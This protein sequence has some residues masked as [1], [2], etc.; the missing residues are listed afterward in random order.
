MI[1]RAFSNWSLCL[2]TLI[3]DALSNMHLTPGCNFLHFI[4]NPQNIFIAAMIMT[5]YLTRRLGDHVFGE[6]W[7]DSSAAG[8]THLSQGIWGPHWVSFWSTPFN[9]FNCCK[10]HFCEVRVC[11]YLCGL[12]LIM[13]HL[14]FS[15]VLHIK[16]DKVRLITGARAEVSAMAEDIFF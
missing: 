12:G 13:Q 7:F 9:P 5:F 6:H 16:I 11:T 15:P 1:H 2:F 10:W 3:L 8:L 14:L 4:R